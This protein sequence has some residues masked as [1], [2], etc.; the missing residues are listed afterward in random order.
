MLCFIYKSL[1]KE[2]LYLYVDKKDDFSK[3]PEA[4]FNSFGKMEFVMDLE[5]T[6]ERKLAKED[7][8]KVIDS[9]T[10]KGFFVQLP[11]INLPA[12]LKIQ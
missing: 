4:L 1:K 7:A 12:P 2:N 11:P 3:V 9:L 10:A 6:P 5:L 8:A